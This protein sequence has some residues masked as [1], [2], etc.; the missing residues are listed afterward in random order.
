MVLTVWH[1]RIK[2]NA[3]NDGDVT[4]D[5]MIALGCSLL[6]PFLKSA[7]AQQVRS[8]FQNRKTK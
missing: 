2:R 3:H 7:Y 5:F 8:G 6:V 4:C 1:G